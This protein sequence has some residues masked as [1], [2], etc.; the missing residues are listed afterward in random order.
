MNIHRKVMRDGFDCKSS[1][2]FERTVSVVG[3]DIPAMERFILEGETP[4]S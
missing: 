2:F 3:E 4:S 1:R